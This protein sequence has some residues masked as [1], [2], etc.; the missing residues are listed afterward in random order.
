[1]Q[2]HLRPTESDVCD[3]AQEYVFLTVHFAQVIL[4]CVKVWRCCWKRHSERGR[5]EAPNTENYLPASFPALL[6]KGRDFRR[7]CSFATS[8]QWWG[9][10]RAPATLLADGRAGSSSCHGSTLREAEPPPVSASGKGQ[11]F[12]TW[13]GKGNHSP[14]IFIINKTTAQCLLQNPFSKH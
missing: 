10:D 12:G 9:G 2:V 6:L 13:S 4:R 8:S 1:M 7:P 5:A 3:G 11:A 14:G